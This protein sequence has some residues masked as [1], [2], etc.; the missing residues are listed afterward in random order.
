MV[1]PGHLRGVLSYGTM[2]SGELFVVTILIIGQPQLFVA[3]L[4]TWGKLNK[5]KIFILTNNFKTVQFDIHGIYVRPGI[6]IFKYNA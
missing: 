6:G 1:V 3:S 4:D 5:C 2:V